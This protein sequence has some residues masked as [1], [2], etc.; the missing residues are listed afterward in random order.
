MY[1][2]QVWVAWGGVVV[3]EIEVL[4]YRQ[5]VGWG[6]GNGA[7]ALHVENGVIKSQV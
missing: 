1:G 5:Q 2:Q 3:G 4:V 6:W 7:V